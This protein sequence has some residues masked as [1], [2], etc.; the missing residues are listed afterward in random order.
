VNEADYREIVNEAERLKRFSSF[1]TGYAGAH[2]DEE[3]AA[4]SDLSKYYAAKDNLLAGFT[5]DYID[6]VLDLAS[7]VANIVGNS[8]AAANDSEAEALA[9]LLEVADLSVLKIVS[10]ANDAN[11]SADLRMRTICELDLRFYSKNSTQWATLLGITPNAV[12]L[13][14]FWRVDRAKYVGDNESRHRLRNPTGE[15]PDE[16]RHDR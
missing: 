1:V 12:R 10:I 13:T 15:W 8:T 7:R 11:L 9:R 5:K 2:P 16:L 6:D 4:K 3:D 14:E